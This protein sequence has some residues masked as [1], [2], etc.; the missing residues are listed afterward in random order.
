MNETINSS[1]SERYA[2]KSDFIWIRE[3]PE[4]ASTGYIAKY[5]GKEYLLKGGCRYASAYQDENS[6][7]KFFNRFDNDVGLEYISQSLFREVLGKQYSPKMFLVQLQEGGRKSSGSNWMLAS[8]WIQN[9]TSLQQKIVYLDSLQTWNFD[10]A[11]APGF[12]DRKRFHISNIEPFTIVESRELSRRSK[13]KFATDRGIDEQFEKPFKGLAKLLALSSLFSLKDFK[14]EHVM[15]KPLDGRFQVSIVDAASN[16]VCTYKSVHELFENL[17]TIPQ[18]YHLNKKKAVKVFEKFASLSDGSIDSLAETVKPLMHP[19]YLAKIVEKIKLLQSNTKWLVEQ[20][21]NHLDWQ[22]RYSD[23]YPPMKAIPSHPIKELMTLKTMFEMHVEEELILEQLRQIR[24]IPTATCLPMEDISEIAHPFLEEWEEGSFDKHSFDRTR[25]SI[26]ISLTL[27]KMFE[28]STIAEDLSPYIEQFHRY[29][30]SEDRQK[31]RSQHPKQ[32]LCLLL[33]YA[34]FCSEFYSKESCPQELLTAFEPKLRQ[35]PHLQKSFANTPPVSEF[36]YL[37]TVFIPFDDPAFLESLDQSIYQLA[38][39]YPEQALPGLNLMAEFLEKFHSLDL[40]PHLLTL[41]NTIAKTDTERSLFKYLNTRDTIENGLYPLVKYH[42]DKFSQ[43]PDDPRIYA[44]AMTC[45][46]LTQKIVMAQSHYY[47][48]KGTN[49][50]QNSFLKVW[51]HLQRSGI[52]KTF[53]WD[54]NLDLELLHSR[55]NKLH[56]LIQLIAAENNALHIENNTLKAL[57]SFIPKGNPHFKLTDDETFDLVLHMLNTHIDPHGLRNALLFL[58][59]FSPV[60]ARRLYEFY[61]ENRRPPSTLPDTHQETTATA[62]TL[63]TITYS[64]FK[65]LDKEKQENWIYYL[66]RMRLRDTRIAV[67]VVRHHNTHEQMCLDALNWLSIVH[68]E[69]PPK[70]RTSLLALAAEHPLLSVRQAAVRCLH[71]T[72]HRPEDTQIKSALM[73]TIHSSLAE[74]ALDHE[75][76]QQICALV[77]SLSECRFDEKMDACLL[78][79]F[80]ALFSHK[81]VMEHPEITQALVLCNMRVI[82]NGTK[83][84]RQQFFEDHPFDQMLHQLKKVVESPIWTNFD[85]LYGI[86]ISSTHSPVDDDEV[87]HLKYGIKQDFEFNRRRVMTGILDLWVEIHNNLPIRTFPKPL[88]LEKL[89]SNKNYYIPFVDFPSNEFLYRGIG[90]KQGKPVCQ[91]AVLEALTM[92]CYTRSLDSTSHDSGN[93]SKRKEE[94]CGTFFTPYYYVAT[95]PIYF[96]EEDGALIQVDAK[97]INQDRLSQNLR[98]EGEGEYNYNVISFGGKSR[99][100]FRRILLHFSWKGSL[101]LIAGESLIAQKLKNLTQMYDRSP[102]GP[103]RKKLKRE[104]YSCLER[105][106]SELKKHPHKTIFSTLSEIQLWEIHRSLTNNDFF[107]NRIVFF[108]QIN[109][110]Q[111]P[112]TNIHLS[113]QDRLAK[114]D[115][116]RVLY[117]KKFGIPFCLGQDEMLRLPFVFFCKQAESLSIIL[118]GFQRQ[119]LDLTPQST[120]EEQANELIRISEK[121]SSSIDEEALDLELLKVFRIAIFFR[122][123]PS[124]KL[125]K[126]LKKPEA[127]QFLGFDPQDPFPSLAVQSLVELYQFCSGKISTEEKDAHIENVFNLFIRE[128]KKLGEENLKRLIT[129]FLE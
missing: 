128:R 100:T 36:P 122:T 1:N 72:S 111:T 46:A 63:P 11:K 65:Q 90:A 80:L 40:F 3:K 17:P 118:D 22:S 116:M 119:V 104:I 16:F 58:D 120:P 32:D 60:E 88:Y 19:S 7:Y 113:T 85:S 107:K 108:S 125:F 98:V 70:I 67:W 53:L 44:I 86:E 114:L 121:F 30:D 10:R 13:S 75:Q 35:L 9:A 112:H 124:S 96:D 42:G 97:T 54:R 93:W 15:L 29:L 76:I 71:V 83:I 2:K 99:Q 6:Q 81:H 64:E 34:K 47:G 94:L 129:L 115:F 127:V 110:K 89:L 5:N 56:Q 24:K 45:F 26:M 37:L 50:T 49:E 82:A 103:V 39:I 101:E 57:C 69:S 51:D 105:L 79:D 59:I 74:T 52:L 48:P 84:E 68:K 31:Y 55:L 109:R 38:E 27:V 77:R 126:A 73:H 18:G 8:K 14:F 102:Q 28:I 23:I 106:T 91:Q 62:Q 41:L 20:H 25:L 12:D 33:D 117:G 21:Q 66:S 78:S 4:G 43:S 95:K 61:R 87:A 123:V 92:G